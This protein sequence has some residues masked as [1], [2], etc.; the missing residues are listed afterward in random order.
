MGAPTVYEQAPPVTYSAP[1]V[2]EQAPPVTYSAPPVYE[3]APP[4]TY[5]A[6][7]IQYESTTAMPVAMSAQTTYAMPGTTMSPHVTTYG[8]PQMAAPQVQF[9]QAPMT[10]QSTTY[11]PPAVSYDQTSQVSYAMSTQNYAT[12][13]Q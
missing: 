10:A 11:A 8:A 6:P 2:Y 12:P 7:A 5:T 4:V 1:T 13:T 3:Q 9:E